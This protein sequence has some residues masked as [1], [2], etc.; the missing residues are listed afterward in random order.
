MTCLHLTYFALKLRSHRKRFAM[1]ANLSFTVNLLLDFSG[2]RVEEDD[3]PGKH[4][5]L[6][7]LCGF[8]VRLL[9]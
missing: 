7:L 4:T 2:V 8:H 5:F 1:T 9:S 6:S 3:C